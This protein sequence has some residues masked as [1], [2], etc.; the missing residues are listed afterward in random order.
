MTHSRTLQHV[1]SADG[2]RVSASGASAWLSVLPVHGRGVRAGPRARST[3][4][5]A[6]RHESDGN[7]PGRRPSNRVN[8]T[9]KRRRLKSRPLA[10]AGRRPRAWHRP[11]R[12]LT[13]C[14]CCDWG[15]ED[16]ERFARRRGAGWPNWKRA[17]AHRGTAGRQI[18]HGAI[19]AQ[20]DPPINNTGNPPK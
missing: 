9:T 7:P 4:L 13:V 19:T 11:G 14:S 18:E 2:V 1:Y 8:C 17:A 16:C 5:T 10:E 15:G 12:R 20:S 3:L 6:G